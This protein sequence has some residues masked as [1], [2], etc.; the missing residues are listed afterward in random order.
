MEQDNTKS[1]GERQTP[2][3]PFEE[4][5]KL[6]EQ[7][8]R[9]F[10]EEV[11]KMT[12]IGQEKANED[13]PIYEAITPAEEEV[14]LGELLTEIEATISRHVV[15]AVEAAKALAAWVV[16]TYVFNLREA[17]A[18]VA[19]QSPEKRCGKTTLLA[20]LS[21]MAAKPLVASN[22]SVGALFRAIDEA[23]P[24]LFIDEA[25]TFLGRNTVM[26]GILN[27]GNT[28][29]TAFVVRLAPK[30]NKESDQ[31]DCEKGYGKSK[32]V[33][34]A[35]WCPKVIAMI[36]KVPETLADRAVVVNMTRKL[37]AE[38]CQPLAE[39]DAEPIRRKCM[40]WAID[41]AQKYEEWPRQTVENVSDRASDTYEPL[42][43]IAE[44]AGEEQ[45][46]ALKLAAQ[47]LC[48]YENTEP[49]A[50][51]LLLDIMAVFIFRQSRRVFSRDL[52]AALQGKSGWVAYDCTSRQPVTELH[53]AQVLRRYSIRPTTVRI[54]PNLSKGYKWEDFSEALCHY[55]PHEEVKR[56]IAELKAMNQLALEAQ[57]EQ[58]R[59]DAS[60]E[61]K[62]GQSAEKEGKRLL[63]EAEDTIGRPDWVGQTKIIAQGLEKGLAKPPEVPAQQGNAP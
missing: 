43:A 42:V 35:C 5:A 30:R 58:A 60:Q 16:H 15:V 12:E 36:G 32:V 1:Q 50:A 54:G 48:G 59:L 19:I 11:R 6:L 29:K 7:K 55:V 41:N 26:R 56:K 46:S 25:D 2:E 10:A 17:A 28:R 4:A 62:A 9:N 33:R 27:S 23:M 53:I 44:M 45:K 40:R 34:Y 20:V 51:N 13:I 38:K 47:K 37:V 57:E 31:S 61:A 3:T 14:N 22:I 18:Y 49:E 24:T 21:E 39:L 63:A 52:A 8:E